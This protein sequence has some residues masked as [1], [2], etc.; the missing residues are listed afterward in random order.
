MVAVLRRIH[1]VVSLFAHEY[2]AICKRFTLQLA[3]KLTCSHSSP[4]KQHNKLFQF[5]ELLVYLGNHF[6]PFVRCCC[7]CKTKTY[8]LHKFS[9]CPAL[10]SFRKDHEKLSKHTGRK[11]ES[12]PSAA[13]VAMMPR[14]VVCVCMLNILK[15]A[16][17]QFHNHVIDLNEL[18][19]IRP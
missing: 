5:N 9:L 17:S 13:A 8:T 16:F 11:A 14:Q 10:D 6:F 18:K 3:R 15:W 1:S 4:L 12:G 7:C 2:S 19:T